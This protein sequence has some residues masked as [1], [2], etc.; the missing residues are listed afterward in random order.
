ML[1]LSI[2]G[3]GDMWHGQPPS[4]GCVLKP[5]I[6]TDIGKAINQPPSGGCVLKHIIIDAMRDVIVSHLRVAV[7]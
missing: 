1:K 2:C 3:Y 6:L 4:G 7:C 5:D